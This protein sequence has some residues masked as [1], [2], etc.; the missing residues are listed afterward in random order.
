MTI[1]TLALVFAILSART[2]QQLDLDELA[3]DLSTK[4]VVFLGEEHDNN[5][6][7]QLQLEIVKRLHGLRPDLV[8]SM[9]MFERDVQ[10]TLDDYLRG[11]IDEE[12][13]LKHSRPWPNYEKHY[14]PIIEY[15]KAN[16]LEVIAA[17]APRPLTRKVTAGGMAAIE[18]RI[19]VAQSVTS[20]KDVYFDK[21]KEA[22]REHPGD[23]LTKEV[24]ERFYLSQCLKDDTMA[25]SIY[26]FRATHPARRPL[27]VHLC[28]KFHSDFGLGT[29]VRLLMRDPLCQV[30][31]VTMEAS[32]EPEKLKLEGDLDRRAHYILSVP[33]E[34]KK[35][36]KKE[37]EEEGAEKDRPEAAAEEEVVEEPIAEDEGAEDPEARAALGLMP[38][39]E[40]D[41]EPG[42]RVESV[43]PGKGAEKA[44]IKDGDRII[45]LA[46]KSVVDLNDY[47]DLMSD[48]RPGQTIKVK[49][50]RDGKTLEFKVKLGSYGR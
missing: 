18:G 42:V 44:G 34:P 41:D 24:L 19:F 27:I 8:L 14:R 17:N 33:E 47:M 43:T 11:R 10:G 12:T 49:I 3:R 32:K 7:H 28:G 1:K 37:A 29:V 31:V 15:A 38:S 2:G 23:G 4:D 22:M 9:E 5:V 35:E 6:G 13:F 45:A 21:F 46:G 39:Y 36:K 50:K 16:G 40:E 48:F 30:G 25:E 26:R 20:K